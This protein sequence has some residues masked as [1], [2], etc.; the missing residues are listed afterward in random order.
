ME[1]VPFGPLAQLP[2]VHGAGPATS[3][4]FQAFD[5]E[6]VEK[7]PEVKSPLAIGVQGA[8]VVVRDLKLYRDIYYRSNGGQPLQLG[9]DEYFMLGDNSANSFDSRSWTI[10]GVPERNFLG[11]PFLLHQP[12]RIGHWTFNGRQRTFPSID[13]SRVRF[14]R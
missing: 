5:L 10:P 7:R 11:K 3:P 9:A 6:P 12:S 1:S 2:P 14:L 8:R 4:L 13:W